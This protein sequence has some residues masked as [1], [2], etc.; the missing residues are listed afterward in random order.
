MDSH[1][2]DVPQTASHMNT[3]SD[4][5]GEVPPIRVELLPGIFAEVHRNGQGRRVVRLLLSSTDASLRLELPPLQVVT[6]GG[7]GLEATTVTLGA[8][9]HLEL[10]AGGQVRLWGDDGVEEE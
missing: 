9:N 7:F 10:H 8:W 1:K 6:S 4:V 3:F 2:I 5:P